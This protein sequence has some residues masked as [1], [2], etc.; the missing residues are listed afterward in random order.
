EFGNHPLCGDLCAPEFN[1]PTG[2]D[3]VSSVEFR[4]L[5]DLYGPRVRWYRNAH[6][7]IPVDPQG[8]SCFLPGKEIKERNRFF[9]W[10]D[11][12]SSGGEQ[13]RALKKEVAREFRSK[14]RL[15]WEALKKFGGDHGFFLASGITFNLLI[16]LIPLI[17]LLLA[18]V[19]TYLYSDQEVLNRVRRYLERAV[20][21]LDPR[22]M[23]NLT[24]IIQD[25]KIVSVLGIGGLIW[26]STWIFSSLRT[27]LHTVF[28]VEKGR[29]LFRGTSVDYLMVCNLTPVPRQNYTASAFR[30][31]ASGKGCYF[32][33]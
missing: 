5:P 1:G 4:N 30:G 22:V 32:L 31:E 8:D 26:V 12:K 28:Q 29:S 13:K 18:L 6:H 25:R 15:F 21:S 33:K 14:L 17:L 10:G 16:C 20:P 7:S 2:R 23:Q 11:E 19:G 9:A 24:T 3:E 27:A